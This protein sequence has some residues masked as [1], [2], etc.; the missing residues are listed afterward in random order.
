MPSVA[1][2]EVD[3]MSICTVCHIDPITEKT[4][5]H[6]ATSLHMEYLL[7]EYKSLADAWK[8]FQGINIYR[9]YLGV[10]A[11]PYDSEQAPKTCSLC[12]VKIVNLA[13]ASYVMTQTYK[14]GFDEKER[15][16]EKQKEID[17][18][19]ELRKSKD[20]SSK[21]RWSTCPSKKVATVHPNLPNCST[22]IIS[23]QEEESIEARQTVS[24]N[25]GKEAVSRNLGKEARLYKSSKN[26][27]VRS[28][29]QGR[30][31]ANIQVPFPF[32]KPSSQVTTAVKPSSHT[33]GIAKPS[34]LAN[35]VEEGEDSDSQAIAG[36]PRRSR[37]RS[38][39][40]RNPDFLVDVSSRRSSVDSK[41][42]TPK[43]EDL[44]A[45]A[46]DST[47]KADTLTIKWSAKSERLSGSIVVPTT[48][49]LP[50]SSTKSTK[51]RPDKSPIKDLQ[52]I[53][54]PEKRPQSSKSPEWP[55]SSK[56]HEKRLQSSKSPEKRPH[57]TQGRSQ[58]TP[59][60]RSRSVS[61][62]ASPR[63]K[64]SGGRTL[65]DRNP[66]FQMDAMAFLTSKRTERDLMTPNGPASDE[67]PEVSFSE[68]ASKQVRNASVSSS[69]K[70]PSRKGTNSSNSR[71]LPSS[72]SKKNTKTS[73]NLEMPSTLVAQLSKPP[74]YLGSKESPA[75]S[76]PGERERG[77]SGKKKSEQIK[78]KEIIETRPRRSG[79]RNLS[80]RN[81]DFQIE[82][83]G[84][85]SPS[86]RPSTD[87]RLSIQDGDRSASEESLAK[88]K[89][90]EFRSKHLNML[91]KALS[92]VGWGQKHRNAKNMEQE[93]FQNAT[94]EEAYVSKI[95]RLVVYFSNGYQPPQ[96][97]HS[98]S[99]QSPGQIK[100][101]EGKNK[102]PPT[103]NKDKDAKK[104]SSKKSKPKEG[105][106]ID[107]NQMEITTRVKT[108]QLPQIAPEVIEPIL[109][110]VVPSEE[111]KGK[112]ISTVV[113]EVA[114]GKRGVLAIPKERVRKISEK[115]HVIVKPVEKSVK[116]QGLAGKVRCTLCGQQ[117]AKRSLKNHILKIH[118]DKECF[119][120]KICHN[121]FTAMEELEMHLKTEHEDRTVDSMLA[122]ETESNASE[123]ELSEDVKRSSR[124]QYQFVLKTG[125]NGK[126]GRRYYQIQ[127]EAKQKGIEEDLKMD[128]PQNVE[129]EPKY[130]KT[131]IGKG[132]PSKTLAVKKA[133]LPEKAVV[134]PSKKA[135]VLAKAKSGDD[136][137]DIFT[138]SEDDEDMSENEL[139][140]DLEAR[141]EVEEKIENGK[142]KDP[143]KGNVREKESPTKKKD[144]EAEEKEN[145]GKSWWEINQENEF[146]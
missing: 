40:E 43:V 54:S 113:D 128:I 6:V 59:S 95:S 78:Q 7:K 88:W 133:S 108:R 2:R 13:K 138:R 44:T 115:S 68:E 52:S 74:G 18:T 37:G 33:P 89:T 103:A 85:R 39:L 57:S 14:K 25:V 139:H 123:R 104:A 82:E 41:D 140:I 66:D 117:F 53:R 56:S 1:S 79:G 71:Q 105:A 144:K 143:K 36:R 24:R 42:S 114:T 47:P 131:K 64:R 125:K 32:V 99:V 51:T 62:E 19:N 145:V 80:D 55:P 110:E 48:D 29:N 50:L 4:F 109:E 49:A 129:L 72:D 146:E 35:K 38:L 60:K 124:S 76:S 93:V 30:S 100:P 77:R 22:R 12:L 23:K 26:G 121:S 107:Y 96:G 46:K 5:Q 119:P 9:T 15:R 73:K 102:K 118:K 132:S 86:K 67:D 122:S 16:N 98:P 8:L 31:L 91:D 20:K 101:E 34:G 21:E 45:S 11:I 116:A 134:S 130:K 127:P 136:D 84:A 63:P 10:T 135:T 97:P 75:T 111:D 120:C 87:S 112:K 27:N 70:S 137:Y 81:P 83:K 90:S 92:S 3:K 61:E 142:S 141:D 28:T 126:Q 106:E 94:S 17:A 69:H 58:S 65:M